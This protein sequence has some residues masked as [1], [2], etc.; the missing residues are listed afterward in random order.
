MSNATELR[1]AALDNKAWPY[2]EAR[3]LIARYP[4]GF[5]D[6]G[7]L[8]ETGYGPSGLPHIGTY[9]EVARTSFVLQALR[10]QARRTLRA[11]APHDRQDP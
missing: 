4:E 11:R 9:G 3:K 5:P 1:A 10:A 6:K 8:F 2:E 7:V